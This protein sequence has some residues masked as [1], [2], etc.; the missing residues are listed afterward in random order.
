MG[1]LPQVSWS[2]TGTDLTATPTLPRPAT[3]SGPQRRIR[4]D[5]DT[6]ETSP[7]ASQGDSEAVDRRSAEE[8]VFIQHAAR[9]RSFFGAAAALS[10]ICSVFMAT[11]HCGNP[12][13]RYVCI[14]LLGSVALTAGWVAR[15]L[16]DPTW[17]NA[18]WLLG[19]AYLA[20]VCGLS[21]VYY[22]GVLS[23]ATV[24]FAFAPAATGFGPN[25]RTALRI[26]LGCAIGY[27][28]LVAG[29]LSGVLPELGV[30]AAVNPHA[31]VRLLGPLMC[32][33]VLFGAYLGS[34]R[35]RTLALATIADKVAAARG[36]AQREALLQ[37]ARAELERALA[38]DGRGRFTGSAIG[39]FRLGKVLGRGAMGEVYDATHEGTGAPAAVKLLHF[40]HLGNPENV[41]RFL[42]EAEIAASLQVPNVV[43]VLEV[44]G[45]TSPLPYL[46][47]ERLDGEDLADG[48]RRRGPMPFDQVVDMVRQ[49]GC[50]LNAARAAG[51]V[52]RDLKPRNLFVTEDGTFKIL[53]FG[54]SKL[55]YGDGTLT[56]D[57]ILGTPGYVAPEQAKGKPVTHRADLFSLGAIAY[58]AITGQPAFGGEHIEEVLYKVTT[59]MPPRPSDLT[60]LHAQVD[61]VMAL[62]LA[63]DAA[64]RFDSG[65]ELAAALEAAQGGRLPRE[66]AARA[67][68]LLADRP[69]SP[70]AA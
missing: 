30:V 5:P 44:G 23:C 40:D 39:S 49:V 69:W 55:A 68:R 51:I 29:I 27:G 6:P 8:A 57:R 15:S 26:Y 54:I 58:R 13:L 60:P 61:L 66:V 3:A 2:G 10:L 50:G 12:T 38:L 7:L 42:R 28:L 62:A 70:I 67:R 59:G 36:L 56:S 37:E 65:E 53:D 41:R 52:H 4:L 64:D 31:H 35:D 43:R 1:A 19:V 46:A 25:P 48:L 20:L 24:G 22:V 9:I 18:R 21:L 45:L 47:M 34:R 17:F 14:G 63:K 33:M 16:G 32:E 11:G